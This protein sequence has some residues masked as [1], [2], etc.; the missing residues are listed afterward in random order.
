M[1]KL[2]TTVKKSPTLPYFIISLLVII[3]TFILWLPFIIKTNNFYGIKIEKPEL[4]I[5][6]VIRHWDGPLYIIPAKTL[7]NKNDQLLKNKPEGLQELYFSAHFPLYPLTLRLFAPLVG[8]PKSI[9]LSTL[10]ASIFLYCFFYYF[11]K[12]NK[13]TEFPFILTVVFLFLTP[14][15]LIVRSVGSPEPLFLL[16]IMLSI[17][18]FQNKKYFF[19]GIFGYL[20]TTTK[21]PGILLFISYCLWILLEILKNKKFE[22]KWLWLLL[23]PIGLI[24]V[25]TLYAFRYGDFFAYFKSG[26]N[27]HLLFPPFKVFSHNRSWIDTAWLEE[28]IFIYFFYLLAIINLIKF[29]L[30]TY[31]LSFHVMCSFMIIFFLAIISV[32][33]RDI[34]RYSLPML[35]F[36]LISLERFFTSKKFIIAL[37]LLLPAIYLYAIN[38]MSYNIAPIN[39]WSPFM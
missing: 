8:Y 5:Y 6:N 7:Y 22:K 33:H 19:S 34:S 25:F 28:I 37:L 36:G 3:S 9:L 4:G 12:K 15:F 14:R 16:L 23:I 35:P 30:K 2:Y 18:F 17:Y 26:D 32:G 38:F 13:L 27:I 20:A 39:D 11:V 10:I 1:N 21:S 29:N 31:R 24:S